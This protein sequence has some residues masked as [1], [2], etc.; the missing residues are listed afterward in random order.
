MTHKVIQWATGYT[1]LFALKYILHN[2]NLQLLGLKFF[3][4]RKEGVDAG[5][6]AGM[7]PIGVPATQDT[8]ALLNLDADCV[9]YMPGD[10]DLGDPTDAGS[11]TQELFKAVLPILESGKNVVTVLT[12]LIAPQFIGP[13]G[14]KCVEELERACRIGG[15]TFFGTGFEPGFMADVLP[16]CL[17]GTCAEVHS[18]RSYEILDYSDYDKLETLQSVGLCVKPELPAGRSP[19]ALLSVW[20]SVPYFVARGIGAVLDEVRVVADFRPAPE[21]FATHRGI[22]VEKGSIAGL[23]FAVEGLVDGDPV[24]AVEHISR[25]R[26]DIALEWPNLLPHGGYR[27]EIE[28]SN[29][30]NADFH[31][32]LP[33]GTGN[34]FADAMASTAAR[35][36]NAVDFVCEA[37]PGVKTFFDLP[38]ITGRH[39]FRRRTGC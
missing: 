17:A 21:T 10:P 14:E 26:P 33:G 5:V 30:V 28:G 23:R 9:I 27:I 6:I 35:A 1:G 7:T 19:S 11:R 3:S 38:M 31:L 18:V 12:S 36:V 29:P 20:R 39:S 15:S 13:E 8:E 16:L 22:T 37:P 2:P 32:A 24:I 25:M 34:S 4:D